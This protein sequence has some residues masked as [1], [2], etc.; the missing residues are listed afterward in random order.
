MCDELGDVVVNA[1]SDVNCDDADPCT[2][3]SCDALLGCAH[4]PIGFCGGVGVPAISDWGRA[5]LVLLFFTAAVGILRSGS[6][7]PRRCV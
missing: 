6:K 5:L 4:E 1:P 7:S 3:D 2:A